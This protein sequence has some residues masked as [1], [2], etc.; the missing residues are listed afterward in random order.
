MATEATAKHLS[1]PYHNEVKEEGNVNWL[2]GLSR[3]GVTAALGAA[4]LFGCGTPLAKWLRVSVDPWMLV[5]LLY[6]GS[7]T[8]LLLYH[9]AR[10]IPSAKLP[11]HEW[12]WLVGAVVAG[13]YMFQ[14][15]GM[16]PFVMGI[17]SLMAFRGETLMSLQTRLTGHRTKRSSYG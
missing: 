9:L 13:G 7:G 3:P 8:G 2:H 1:E 4:F 12:P 11:R 5:G 14:M 6:L 17:N 10:R 15:F 16:I